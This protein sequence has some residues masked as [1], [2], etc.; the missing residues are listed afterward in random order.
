MNRLLVSALVAALLQ[1]GFLAWVVAGRAAVLRD[2][3]EV[4]LKVEPVDPRDLLRGDY[5]QLGFEISRLPVELIVDRA[6]F[7]KG[8]AR[9][10][11]VR[12]RRE[13]DGFWRAASAYLGT[14]PPA[15]VDEVDLLGEVPA[16]WD[17]Q[18]E[19]VVPVSFGLE[20]FYL[21]EGEGRAVERDMR[22]RSFGIRVAVAES[23][24]GQIKALVDDG[25]VLFQEP[26]Y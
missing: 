23:G 17:W 14:P 19:G 10:I 18:G 12:L 2:G 22:A 1:I 4:L 24:A 9:P 11:T 15:P 25:A 13:G 5:V 21:P 3:R 7:A 16:G 6:Q 8:N 26:L 20:R